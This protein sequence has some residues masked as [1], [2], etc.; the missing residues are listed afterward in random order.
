MYTYGT[1]HVRC[2]NACSMCK[3][4]APRWLQQPNPAPAALLTHCTTLHQT[5]SVNAYRHT[6]WWPG[7]ASTCNIM[8]NTSSCFMRHQPVE[9]FMPE[10][11]DVICQA[12]L[13][14]TQTVK[15]ASQQASNAKARL[16]GDAREMPALHR[17]NIMLLLLLRQYDAQNTWLCADFDSNSLQQKGRLV[18]T[19]AWAAQARGSA[20]SPA[21]IAA[22]LG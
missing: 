22:R 6:S 19:A 9:W 11:A 7:D 13:K 10:F 17:S 20:R 5:A 4:A 1:Y 8:A 2:G 3:T 21:Q 18:I 12:A 15:Q 16:T 14:V